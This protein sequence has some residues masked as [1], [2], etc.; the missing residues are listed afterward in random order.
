[1]GDQSFS[2]TIPTTNPPV[3]YS[4]TSGTLP[5]GITINQATG[6]LS[7][8][9][10]KGGTYTLVI[11]ATNLKG[12]SST[13]SFTINIAAL[14]AGIVGAFHGHIE[15]SSTVNLTPNPSLGARFQMTTNANGTAT[16]ESV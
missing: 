14:Q 2:L 4:V 15:R 10:T 9:P 12:N 8:V 13:P 11:K 6:V 3:T 5:P 7:G 1:V 16:G